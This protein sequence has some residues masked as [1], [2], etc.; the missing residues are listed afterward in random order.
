[1]NDMRIKS[2]FGD[3]DVCFGDEIDYRS[4]IN[5]GDIV[6][7]DKKVYELYKSEFAFLNDKNAIFIEATEDQKS[8]SGLIPVIDEIIKRGFHKN[9]TL[10]AIGGGITQDCVA[11]MASILY[12][13]VKWKLI[14]T[15]LLAQCDSCI[16]S[17]TS[18]NFS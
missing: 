9:N 17:K 13:G 8:Y 5:D 16:G 2:F 7:I 1:M 12:R 3:Y 4:V 18:I 11:F 6:V 14:P 15:T 10:I